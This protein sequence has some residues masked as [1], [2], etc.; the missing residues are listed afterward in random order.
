[1]HNLNGMLIA[2]NRSGLLRVIAFQKQ[3]QLKYS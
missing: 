1:M 2:L 3:S